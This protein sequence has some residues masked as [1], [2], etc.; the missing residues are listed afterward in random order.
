MTAV[1]SFI[2]LVPVGLVSP[3]ADVEAILSEKN[4]L[5]HLTFS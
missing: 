3:A 2:T 1:K 5:K 4:I